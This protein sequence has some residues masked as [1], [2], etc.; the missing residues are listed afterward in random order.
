MP[1]WSSRRK[2]IS[3]IPERSMAGKLF[4]AFPN[5]NTA[6]GIDSSDATADSSEE[7]YRIRGLSL[8]NL[9]YLIS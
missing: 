1:E 7:G 8:F 9:K 5:R 3:E 2:S 6:S 4:V